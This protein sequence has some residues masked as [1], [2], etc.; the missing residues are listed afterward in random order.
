MTGTRTDAEAGFGVVCGRKEILE[1]GRAWDQLAVFH[2]KEGKGVAAFLQAGWRKHFPENAPGDAGGDAVP[3][4]RDGDAPRDFQ[5]GIHFRGF[6]WAGLSSLTLFFR[7][8]GGKRVPVLGSGRSGFA[9]LQGL[10]DAGSSGQPGGGAEL[11]EVWRGSA[12]G[13][14][15]LQGLLYALCGAG[16]AGVG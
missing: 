10:R 3:V 1:L 11:P 5:A 2:V 12:S 8:T 6:L 14:V 15:E 7:A 13:G 16:C 9:L 4:L